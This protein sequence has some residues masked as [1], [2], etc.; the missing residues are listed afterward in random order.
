MNKSEELPSISCSLSPRSPLTP[1]LKRNLV[2]VRKPTK[3]SP[4]LHAIMS[5]KSDETN[6]GGRE[7]KL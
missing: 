2:A 3:M 5:K 1:H 7:T 4:S 6:E